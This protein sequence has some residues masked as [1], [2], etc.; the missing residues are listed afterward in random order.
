[1]NEADINAALDPAL[2]LDPA[3]AGP[4][5]GDDGQRDGGAS[6][7]EID[8]AVAAH[9]AVAAAAALASQDALGAGD[10]GDTSLL[11]DGGDDLTPGKSGGKRKDDGSSGAR[12]AKGKVAQCNQLRDA[13]EKAL[14]GV[15]A[16]IDENDGIQD[17]KLKIARS[18]DRNLGE[19][20]GAYIC[21]VKKG[22]QC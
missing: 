10:E 13:A 22:T 11:Q 16:I 4:P 20:H 21:A 8:A 17:P 2:N 6:I 18:L 14:E 15:W 9:A 5:H 3:L 1:M 12:L 7:E 19:L